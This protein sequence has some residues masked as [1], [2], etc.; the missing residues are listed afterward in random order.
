MA[1]TDTLQDIPAF[2]TS[3]RAARESRKLSLE[4]IS[5]RLRLN[6]DIIHS[7]ETG[8]FQNAPPAIFMRGYLRSYARLL[9]FSDIDIQNAL[10]ASG[11]KNNTDVPLSPKTHQTPEKSLP[12]PWIHWGSVS[13]LLTLA[14][15]IFVWWNT[16][17]VALIREKL[18]AHS[19]AMTTPSPEKPAINIHNEPIHPETIT[20]FP[21]TPLIL[22]NG[23]G[24]L[25][26][27]GLATPE[28]D[29]SNPE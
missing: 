11:L 5:N 13:L 1:H 4:D 3:L 24:V 16:H 20:T 8:N 25:S 14:F 2:G 9:D 18:S 19:S 22:P 23:L 29:D 28:S 6:P 27:A 7:L 26:D 10:V 17:P 15:V 21:E 12:I